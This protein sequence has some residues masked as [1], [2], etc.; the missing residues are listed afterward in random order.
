MIVK[1]II[2]IKMSK[3]SYRDL[4]ERAKN[5]LR[6]HAD[7]DDEDSPLQHKL[8]TKTA[9][10][11][12]RIM[13]RTSRNEKNNG[14]SPRFEQK[15]TFQQTDTSQKALAE[16]I[17]KVNEDK[18]DVKKIARKILAKEQD[19]T[20]KISVLQQQ[21]SELK[22]NEKIL[23][24]ELKRQQDLNKD[25][26]ELQHTQE[27][28]FNDYMNTLQKDYEAQIEEYKSRI[29]NLQEQLNSCKNEN[30]SLHAELSNLVA[31][32]EKTNETLNEKILRISKENEELLR[33]TKKDLVS[34]MEETKKLMSE[35]EGLRKTIVELQ[36]SVFFNIGIHYSYIIRKR[37]N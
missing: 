35:N 7:S 25:T 34:S 11:S 2:Q 9:I 27:Q 31:Q 17:R 22:T 23:V 21:I 6:K 10:T 8:V 5:L 13:S 24:N 26:I 32:N 1:F 18:R 16:A 15:I 30:E 4:E 37:K 12:P 14:L 19:D 20:Y 3:K 28:K 29:G 33:D 36:N